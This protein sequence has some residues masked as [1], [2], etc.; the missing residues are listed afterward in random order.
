MDGDDLPVSAFLDR[1]DGQFELGAS[2]YEKRGTAVNVPEWDAAK[3]IQCNLC[4]F[5]CSHATIRPYMVSEDEIKAAPDNMKVA[6]TKPKASEYKFTMSVSPLDCMGCGECITVCP[7]KAIQM[8]P[9]ESQAAEQPVWD[10]SKVIRQEDPDAPKER[11]GNFSG[12][13]LS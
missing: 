11:K 3:C 10:P 12:G 1:A 8:V 4:A 5:V 9:Q 7:T 13:K 2:A 6:D